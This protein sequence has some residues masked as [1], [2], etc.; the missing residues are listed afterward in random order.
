M[1]TV[2][3]ERALK[4]YESAFRI[5]LTS[6]PILRDLGQLCLRTGDLPRA[7]KT[8]RALLLQRLTPDSG[9]RKA[10]VYYHL[11]E[12]ASKQGD[13]VKAKSMLMR[14]LSEAKDHTDAR[15]LLDSLE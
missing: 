4:L 7:Q 14:A 2:R 15:Q 8:F 3:T 1:S 10:D 6:V 11:G 9:I 13:K 5:N 12:I